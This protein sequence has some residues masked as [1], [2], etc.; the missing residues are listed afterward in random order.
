M[1]KSRSKLFVLIDKRTALEVTLRNDFFSPRLGLDEKHLM[2]LVIK[3]L[4]VRYKETQ[5]KENGDET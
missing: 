1:M 5:E 4:L 2:E 3:D